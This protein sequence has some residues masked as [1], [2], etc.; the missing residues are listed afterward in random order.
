MA[1]NDCDDFPIDK[2]TVRHTYLVTYSQADPQKFA[3]REIL[4]ETVAEAFNSGSGKV[5][6]E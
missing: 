4:G 6:T 2:K 5:G 3:T 1:E